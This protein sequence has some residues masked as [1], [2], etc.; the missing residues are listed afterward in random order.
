MK[1]GLIALGC[2]VNQYEIES[3]KEKF[4]EANYTIVPF[5]EKA[6]IYVI[7]TCS[8][9]NNSDVKDRKIIREAYRRNNDAIIVVMGCYSQ[10]KYEEVK[11]LPRVCIILGT[12]Y[13]NNIVKLVE[14]I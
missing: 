13:R 10:I 5:E 2:K 9:T 14:R 4:K 8:V 1:V 6:D 7:N 3:A 12:N 11:E